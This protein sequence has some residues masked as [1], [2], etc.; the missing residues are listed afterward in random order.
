MI[1]RDFLRRLVLNS[2]CDDFENVDQ[3]ILRDIATAAAKCGLRVERSE[4][5]DTLASLI[6]DGL[7]KAY[8]L[9]G[10]GP[11]P[12]SGELRGMPPV[13]VIEEDFRTYF[14]ITKQG[15]DLHRSVDRWWPFDEDGN[16]R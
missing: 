8:I 1:R 13:E 2:V 11:S 6:A 12:F 14:Y 16:P 5:V 15:A 9:P 10:P 4:V 7:V 3:V